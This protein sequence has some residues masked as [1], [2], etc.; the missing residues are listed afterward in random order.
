MK[1]RDFLKAL[2]LSALSVVVPR[3]P[4]ETGPIPAPKVV[5]EPKAELPPDVSRLFDPDTPVWHFANVRAVR[6]HDLTEG[7]IIALGIDPIWQRDDGRMHTY[8][9]GWAD[10]QARRKFAPAWDSRWGKRYPYDSNPW[11]WL[12]LVAKVE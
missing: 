3:L 10:D 7:D 6:V 4:I 5:S 1:R 11:A 8:Y 2:G 9:A 12:A